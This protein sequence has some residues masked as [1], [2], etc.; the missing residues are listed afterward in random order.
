MFPAHNASKVGFWGLIFAALV[1]YAVNAAAPLGLVERAPIAWRVLV[2]AMV[3]VPAPI[4]L[5]VLKA[6]SLDM[7]PQPKLA[8]IETKT[9]T[10]TGQVSVAEPKPTR[11]LLG[12]GARMKV[13]RPRLKSGSETNTDTETD[14]KTTLTDEELYYTLSV[15]KRYNGVGARAAKHLNMSVTAVNKRLRTLYAKDPGAVEADVP[16]WVKRNIGAKVE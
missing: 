9:I 4:A 8:G 2:L 11:G 1:A 7:V 12:F 15:M 16:E 6:V 5:W 10:E 14:T 3:A 13:E